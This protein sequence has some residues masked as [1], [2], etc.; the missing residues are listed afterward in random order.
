MRR[1]L[2]ERFYEHVKHRDGCMLWTGSPEGLCVD[3][4][5]LAPRQLAWK[6]AYG[7]HAPQLVV[8]CGNDRC[9][10][11]SHLRKTTKIVRRQ[12]GRVLTDEQVEEIRSAHAGGV[13]QVDLAKAFGVTISHISRIVNG[14]R[15]VKPAA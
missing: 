2:A 10:R 5:Q 14:N 4:R 6:L 3:G 11:P 1:T 12:R 13:P 9:V 8:T 7:E 15:R